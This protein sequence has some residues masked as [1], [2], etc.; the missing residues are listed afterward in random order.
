MTQVIEVRTGARL[1]FGLFATT[2]DD[3]TFGGIGMMIDRPGFLIRSW[4]S[5]EDGVSAPPTL[6]RRVHDVV[7]QVRSRLPSEDMRRKPLTSV[8]VHVEK[9]IP[10]HRGFG[11][12][13]Q[14]TFAVAAAVTAALDVSPSFLRGETFGRGERSGVG[15]VGF[16]KGGFLVD[17][18]SRRQLEPGVTSY[19]VP[20]GWRFV[21]VDPR[22]PCGPSGST[23]A[24]GFRSLSAMPAEMTD[25]LF[26]IV[27]EAVQPGLEGGDFV[28]FAGGVME[29]NRLVGRHFAPAQGGIYAHPLIRDL[30]ERLTHTDWPHVAQS[31]WGP[32]AVVLCEDAN[33]A[34]RL[35][36]HLAQTLPADSADVFIARP[37]NRGAEVV[38]SG[39][40]R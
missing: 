15:T 10:P 32:A 20:E 35:V 1:H 36:V 26:Y 19:T 16:S 40:D 31:S 24:A 7:T 8:T 25:L 14:L 21:V 9:C 17:R 6:A 33:S 11:S 27:V 39:F 12:G 34:D 22:G 28:R 29:F 3:G 4:Q 5:A 2:P 30:A 23:E 37:L 18:G 13:T 38:R